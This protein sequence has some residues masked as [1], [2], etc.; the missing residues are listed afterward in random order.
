MEVHL[1]GKKLCT[2][3]VGANA[4][5]NTIVD[6]VNQGDDDWW[7]MV[8]VGGLENDEFLLWARSE[9]RV[10]DEIKIRVIEDEPIDSPMERKTRAEALGN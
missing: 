5:S 7:M 1:N 9:L 10:G 2:A 8:R 3:G 4:V 6:V